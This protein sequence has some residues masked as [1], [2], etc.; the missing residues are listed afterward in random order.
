M[1]GYDEYFSLTDDSG[2]ID[3]KSILAV[4]VFYTSPSYMKITEKP[5][6]LVYDLMPNIGG[7]MGLFLGISALSFVEFLEI[8]IEL[9]AFYIRKNRGHKKT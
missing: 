5:S 4:N 1:K 3:Q 8:G 9:V 7:T 2:V 6:I